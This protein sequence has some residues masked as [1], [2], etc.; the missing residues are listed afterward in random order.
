LSSPTGFA[1]VTNID[2]KFQAKTPKGFLEAGKQTY[3][4]SFSTGA[5]PP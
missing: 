5:L 4:G 1:G 2:G 3:I